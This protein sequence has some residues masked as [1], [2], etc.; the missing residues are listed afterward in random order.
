MYTYQ[1]EFEA[2]GCKIFQFGSKDANCIL[3]IDPQTEKPLEE[4]KALIGETVYVEY[5]HLVEALVIGE[6]SV[7]YYVCLVRFLSGKLSVC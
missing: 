3:T 5:P 2:A 6:L 4:Y 1:A 7:L